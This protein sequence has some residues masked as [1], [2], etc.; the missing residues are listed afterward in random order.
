L[1][2]Q[3][4]IA[5]EF[6]LSLK[7]Q[8]K[9]HQDARFTRPV[10]WAPH[11]SIIHAGLEYQ[12]AGSNCKPTDPFSSDFGR[13]LPVV[14]VRSVGFAKRAA[15]DWKT[16]REAEILCNKS[17]ETWTKNMNEKTEVALIQESFGPTRPR[18]GSITD[19]VFKTQ[20]SP[21][22]DVVSIGQEFTARVMWDDDT[23][24]LVESTKLRQWNEYHLLWNSCNHF[25]ARFLDS[26]FNP[27]RVLVLGDETITYSR[28]QAEKNTWTTDPQQT[29]SLVYPGRLPRSVVRFIEDIG[30]EELQQSLK[31][32]E[33]GEILGIPPIYLGG[34]NPVR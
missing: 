7:P 24:T 8:L 32:L 4:R 5:L 11:T 14:D 2:Q 21:P 17:D 18:R 13:Y 12:D 20:Q 30:T 28:L 26:L 16:K 1:R 19:F 31:K 9:Q 15:E 6:L 34:I 10:E 3:F 25:A 23:E 29:P 33:R 27:E 22:T